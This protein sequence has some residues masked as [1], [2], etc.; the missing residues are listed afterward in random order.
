MGEQAQFAQG[1]QVADSVLAVGK[2][3]GNRES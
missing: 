3:G 1:A 2:R